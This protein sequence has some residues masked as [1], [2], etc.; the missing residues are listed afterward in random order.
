LEKATSSDS[1]TPEPLTVNVKSSAI[2]RR[3]IIGPIFKYDSSNWFKK[4]T[5]L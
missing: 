1:P 3:E 5:Y 2:G 4:R